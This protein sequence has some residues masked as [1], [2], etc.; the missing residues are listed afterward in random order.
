MNCDMSSA[1][2]HSTLGPMFSLL[3]LS[4]FALPNAATVT[5]KV[6]GSSTVFP[7]V[8]AWAATQLYGFVY[9]KAPLL[10]LGPPVV[11]FCFLAGGF[12]H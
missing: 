5:V 3:A 10:L 6:A 9:S 12:P 4:F 1:L 11:P 7:V 2:A 8:N